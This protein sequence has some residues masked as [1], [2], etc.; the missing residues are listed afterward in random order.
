MRHLILLL[1]FALPCAAQ[2]DPA[3]QLQ[4]QLNLLS[5]IKGDDSMESWNELG[6]AA[7]ALP[8]VPDA[9]GD[10]D[11]RDIRPGSQ[12]WDALIAWARANPDVQ[13][14]IK[15]TS[16]RR[17]LG[18]PYGEDAVPEAF[19]AGGFSVTLPDLE[20]STTPVFGWIRHLEKVATWAKVE[21]WRR[22]AE[23]DADGAI[24]LME[25]DVGMLR[26]AAD[27]GFLVEK[28]A[29]ITLLIDA[30]LSL[31]EMIYLHLEDIS[32]Q[33]LNDFAVGPISKV[34]ADRDRL[35]LPELDRHVHQALVDASFDHATGKVDQAEFRR[36]FT[37]LLGDESPVGYAGID[38]RW[39]N[40]ARYQASLEASREQLDNLYDDWWRRWR[41]RNGTELAAMILAEPPHSERLNAVRYAGVLSTLG[42]MDQLVIDRDRLIAELD[43]TS[44]AAGIAAYRR[45]RG[46]YP[47]F[48][49]MAYGIN[50]PR[51]K[52]F[53]RY[54]SDNLP[55][56][57]RVPASDWTVNVGTGQVVVPAGTG[58]LYSR[59][60]D[61]FD[62]SGA[63]HSVGGFDGDLI[64]WP[65]VSALKVQDI[66]PAS[67]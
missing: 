57:Y 53:D 47:Q 25:K 39:R 67:N 56:L 32:A 16:E 33:R 13:D 26:K 55:F 23:G 1:V 20:T 42:D 29:A 64:I 45:H 54:S 11:I 65:P 19:S 59:G 2:A 17:F 4:E 62:N 49:R 27:R 34:R 61:G 36:R 48:A 18:L 15:I 44:V 51:H 41:V 52:D 66:G 14:A 5:E 9:A 22:L 21:A 7:I 60:R 10:A 3:Q 38:S 50:I 37:R 8:A 43:A 24:D 63:R 46:A 6:E 30:V 12:G 28:H 58:L 35:L 31:R 40:L